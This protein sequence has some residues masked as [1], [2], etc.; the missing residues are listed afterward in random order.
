[1]PVTA[2]AEV[3]A[4]IVATVR[5]IGRLPSPPLLRGDGTSIAPTTRSTVIPTPSRTHSLSDA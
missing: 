3:R 5:T 2:P 1:M 4:T